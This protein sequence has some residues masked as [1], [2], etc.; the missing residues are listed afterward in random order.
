V[1]LC[2]ALFA[3]AAVG[4][5]GLVF[6]A[7]VGFV[8]LVVGFLAGDAVG[9]V[10]SNFG[11]AVVGFPST[12]CCSVSN[13]GGGCRPDVAGGDGEVTKSSF[14]ANSCAA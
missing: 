13:D 6:V 7:L 4:V 9:K 14:D 1:D 8:A 5:V 10:E 11:E 3:A 2:S 12:D